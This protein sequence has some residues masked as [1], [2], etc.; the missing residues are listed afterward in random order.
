MAIR[1]WTNLKYEVEVDILSILKNKERRIE[2]A[3]LKEEAFTCTT[4]AGLI[5]SWK[6]NDLSDYYDASTYIL[7]T[8]YR[9]LNEWMSGS[10]KYKH[11][12][13]KQGVFSIL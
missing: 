9:D 13:R 3:K 8:K 7:I 6:E 10:L 2:K 4:C 5:P 1:S 12:T 11:H